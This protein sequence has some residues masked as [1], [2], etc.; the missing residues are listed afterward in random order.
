VRLSFPLRSAGRARLDVFDVSGRRI[1]LFEREG[2]AAG[3][4]TIEWDG[5]D[6]AGR[7]VPAGVYLVRVSTAD[8]AAARRV[9]R[10]R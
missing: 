4:A 10:I 2:L 7:P 8:G 9:T 3:T 1:R 6:R 5:R